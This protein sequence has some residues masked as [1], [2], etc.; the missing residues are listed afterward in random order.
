MHR[1]EIGTPDTCISLFSNDDTRLN[2]IKKVIEQFSFLIEQFSLQHNTQEHPCAYPS[3]S[4]VDCCQNTVFLK[5]VIPSL[6]PNSYIIAIIKSSQENKQKAFELG[7]KDYIT[8][9]IIPQELEVRLESILSIIKNKFFSTIE[10]INTLQKPITNTSK[11]TQLV[12][13]TCQYLLKNIEKN[14]SIEKLAALMCSNRNSLT[15]AF[16]KE[17]GATVFKWL[18]LQRMKKATYLLETTEL[19]IQEISLSVGYEDP[20]NFATSYRVVNN[21]SPR[22][23]RKKMQISKQLEY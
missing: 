20:A 10:G 16:K 19:S 12:E 9:P 6:S 17:L 21:I 4:L 5:E 23:Y 14:P 2:L 18:R 11:K 1:H 13:K 15:K 22:E 7:V 8:Y 3:I